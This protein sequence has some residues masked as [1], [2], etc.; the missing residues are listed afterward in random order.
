MG[1]NRGGTVEEGVSLEVLEEG[2][3]STAIIAG[4]TA[5]GHHQPTPVTTTGLTG[6]LVLIVLGAIL[7]QVKLLK[8]KVRQLTAAEI[9]LFE[10]GDVKSINKVKK[11]PLTFG[12][13]NLIFTN[14]LSYSNIECFLH[15]LCLW[16][17]RLISFPITSEL[18]FLG[19][20]M[21]NSCIQ[22]V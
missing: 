21:E 16:M 3:D 6:V 7:Y 9:R 20:L 17:S 14:E 2:L 12:I 1:T 4:S 10:E 19:G 22:G 8:Q 15:R 11:L 5:A 13:K 18:L